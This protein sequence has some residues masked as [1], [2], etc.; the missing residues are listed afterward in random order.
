MEKEKMT[1][2]VEEFGK[3]NDY[4]LIIK[5]NKLKP[6]SQQHDSSEKKNI[7]IKLFFSDLKK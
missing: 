6:K 5:K 1:I 4:A 2:S 7:S 3:M